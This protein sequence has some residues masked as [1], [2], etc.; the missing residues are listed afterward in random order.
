MKEINVDIIHDELFKE[1]PL[2]AYSESNDYLTWK[3]QIEEKY[4]EFLGMKVI[5]ENICDLNPEIES[6]EEFDEY[7]KVRYVFESEKNSLVPAY[8]LIPKLGKKKYPLLIALQG[9]TTGFHISLGISKYPDIDSHYIDTHDYGVY[10]V[11]QG[12][13]TLCIE[14]RGMGERTTKKDI[15]QP[16]LQ[17]GCYHTAMTALLLGRTIIGERVWDIHRSIDSLKELKQYKDLCD[18]DDITVLGHSGGG[19]ATYYAACY[20]KRI[21]MAISSCSISTYKDSIGDYW[22]CSCNYIPNIAR[23]M[24]MGELA[25]LIAP[26]KLII[27]NGEEDKIFPLEGAKQVYSTIEKIYEKE[28][29]KNNCRFVII[30]E[31][32][33]Y[34]DKNLT[35]SAIKDLR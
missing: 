32:P 2:L 12:F 27:I 21:K 30:P 1:K 23:Y 4:L 28:G 18:F 34:F 13:I 3:K 17:C 26:R 25:C 11:K 5:E 10:A 20:D 31:K 29:V 19:T 7:T 6:V 24:D 14:Q 16:A 35:F 9:H 22:H 8:L 15:R 33:H